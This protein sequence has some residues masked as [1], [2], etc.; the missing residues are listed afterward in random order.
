MI[1]LVSIISLTELSI[2]L[3]LFM[4]FTGKCM[5]EF[6]LPAN[7]H[8]DLEYLLRKSRSRLSSPGSLGSCVR[9]IVDLFEGSTAQVEPVLMAA[10]K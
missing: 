10:R 8:P 9:E 6:D 7:Y 3:C 4:V 5:T 2:A 1:V